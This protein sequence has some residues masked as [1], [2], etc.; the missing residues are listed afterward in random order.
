MVCIE[1]LAVCF[2]GLIVIYFGIDHMPF[3]KF[4][5]HDAGGNANV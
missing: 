1:G 5:Y 3:G 4:P 2:F